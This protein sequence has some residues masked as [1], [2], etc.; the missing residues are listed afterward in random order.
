MSVGTEIADAFGQAFDA[1]RD[2]FGPS[3]SLKILTGST[4]PYTTEATYTT[5]WY[6]PKHEYTELATGKK[7]Q[8]LRIADPE[9]TRL[10]SLKRMTAVQV[11][12][13]VYK[14]H[15]KDS[16]IGSVPN[17]EFKIYAT[18]ERV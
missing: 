18:G 10:A 4:A 9:G 16:F 13:Q 12:T 8:K 7:F 17:Y 11:G 14:F 15:S 3:G 2:I 5:D 6:L 1:L